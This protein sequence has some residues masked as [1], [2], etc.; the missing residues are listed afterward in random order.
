M[1]IFSFIFLLFLFIASKP[2]FSYCQNPNFDIEKGWVLLKEGD[3]E[4]AKTIFCLESR[5]P[6]LLL[7]LYAELGLAK[8]AIEETKY[9]TAK[10]HLDQLKEE[11]LQTSSDLWYEW[12]LTKADLEY[13]QRNYDLA[14]EFLE[15]AIPQKN[16]ALAPFGP[17]SLLLLSQV[18]Q[19]K[20]EEAEDEQ[21]KKEAVIRIEDAYRQLEEFYPSFFN[22]KLFSALYAL[23]ACLFQDPKIYLQA[24]KYFK[25]IDSTLS[26]ASCLIQEGSQGSLEQAY[27]ILEKENS[28]ESEL[29]MAEYLFK[30]GKIQEASMALSKT[31]LPAPYHDK[32]LFLLGKFAYEQDLDAACYFEELFQTYPDSSLAPEALYWAARCLENDPKQ[33]IYYTRLYQEFKTHPLAP[34]AYFYCYSPQSYLLGNRMAIKHLHAFKSLFPDSPL[35]LFVLYLE[36]LDYLHDRRSPE[37]KWLS[38]K[39][40]IAAIDAFMEVEMQFNRLKLSDQKSRDLKN[41]ATLERAKTN[42]LIANQAKGSKQLIYFDYAAT[43]FQEILNEKF[44]YMEE[45]ALYYTALILWHKGKP[46]EAKEKFFELISKNNIGSYYFSK[47]LYQL[48]MIEKEL[49]NYPQAIYFFDLALQ[50]KD[51]LS[52][53][54]ILDAMIEKSEA[55]RANGDLDSSMLQLSE[56]VDYQAV[57][58]LRLKAMYFRAEIY[59]LQGRS[60]LAR[61]QL[62]SLSLIGGSKDPWALKAKDTLRQEYGFN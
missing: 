52:I 51:Y 28:P 7:H 46:Q 38:R 3:L 6:I 59:R 60:S 62:E 42:F 33:L 16:H 10:N 56:V 43:V 25:Q 22:P 55:Y 54:E 58:S 18:W 12:L 37:G 15:K 20:G 50:N 29:L 48:G 53:D 41:R 19:K 49:K 57:S 17:K 24:S 39:N 14:L 32:Q 26:Q 44:P 23:K 27:Q 61:K 11:D 34:E 5:S 30:K 2:I 13:R 21:M 9:E 35:L 4:N 8:I 1:K 47:S 36:G 31:K 45:E 40:L